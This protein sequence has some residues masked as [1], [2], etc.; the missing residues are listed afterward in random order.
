LNIMKIS[1]QVMAAYQEYLDDFDPSPQNYG[2][3]YSAPL[4]LHEWMLAM[5]EESDAS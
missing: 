1:P 3:D 4:D 2:D 5:E